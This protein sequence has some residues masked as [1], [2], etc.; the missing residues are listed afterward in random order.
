MAN[1]DPIASLEAE[2]KDVPVQIETNRR[3]AIF[4][5]REGDAPYYVHPEAKVRYAR[6]LWRDPNLSPIL[7]DKEGSKSKPVCS[8]PLSENTKAYVYDA[9]GLEGVLWGEVRGRAVD[10]FL[11]LAGDMGTIIRRA[12]DLDVS[13]ITPDES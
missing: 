6:K 11:G 4:V 8:A 2:A 3:K 13:H 10:T 5:D 1:I 12:Q 9:P 7:Y